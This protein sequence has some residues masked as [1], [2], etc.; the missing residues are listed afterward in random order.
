MR[1]QKLMNRL[2]PKRR[3]INV[4]IVVGLGNPG[5]KYE[6]TPH[7][8]G[9]EA[10]EQL[11]ERC[12]C[13]FKHSLRF[14]AQIAK[15][16][17]GADQALLVKPQTFMNLSGEAV[18]ALLRF[19]KAST[20]DL[21]VLFDDVDLDVGRIRIRPGGGSGGHKG[22]TSVIQHVGTGD[23]VRVRMGVGRGVGAGDVVSH[24]LRKIASAHRERVDSMIERA[25]DAVYKI[26]ESGVD[27]AMNRFN[28]MEPE[29]S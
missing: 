13:Q 23:F 2:R 20:A 10:V 1:L 15:T 9:F 14:K 7:N 19:Y 25:V 21:I 17:I 22:L 6:G 27:A 24:V 8:V 12:G 29:Q 26:L 16:T 4:K 28:S 11:A 18:G 3:K 5:A